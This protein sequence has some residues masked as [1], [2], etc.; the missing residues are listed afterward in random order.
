MIFVYYIALAIFIFFIIKI[1]YDII[2]KCII[3]RIKLNKMFKAN[4]N[5][6]NCKHC[7][8]YIS[9]GWREVRECNLDFHKDLNYVTGE[10]IRIYKNANFTIGTRK[11]HWE[12]RKEKNV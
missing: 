10:E 4:H 1:V 12:P 3:K 8:Y 2:N 5:C 11:C 6:K 7:C 9:Q